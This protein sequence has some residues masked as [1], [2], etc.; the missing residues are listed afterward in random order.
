MTPSR[1]PYLLI[2]VK[3][4]PVFPPRVK[5]SQPCSMSRRQSR[6]TLLVS[7]ASLTLVINIVKAEHLIYYVLCSSHRSSSRDI[8]SVR[9]RNRDHSTDIRLAVCTSTPTTITNNIIL[10]LAA[11]GKTI[12]A[13]TAMG[14]PVDTAGP[15]PVNMILRITARNTR[16]SWPA[17]TSMSPWP[18]T[19]QQTRRPPT[20]PTCW[21]RSEGLK[22]TARSLVQPQPR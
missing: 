2:D 11:I 12:A 4:I 14:A 8:G 21:R 17:L 3:T 19:A 10:L 5:V 1:P 16:R 13:A 22:L 6:Q 20:R 7:T 9:L 18:S 15:G